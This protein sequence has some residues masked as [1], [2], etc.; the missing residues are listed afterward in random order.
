MTTVT[1]VVDY[2]MT[3]SHAIRSSIWPS[4]WMGVAMTVG[5]YFAR[6]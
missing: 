1:K 4:L 5:D 2:R 6:P 3:V